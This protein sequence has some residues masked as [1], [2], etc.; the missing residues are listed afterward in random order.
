MVTYY[1]LQGKSFDCDTFDG[2]E[3]TDR[4]EIFQTFKRKIKEKVDINPELERIAKD[5]LP[6]PKYRASVYKY[7]DMFFNNPREFPKVDMIDYSDFE[8]K[9]RPFPPREPE[10]D[11]DTEYERFLGFHETYRN[12]W[13]NITGYDYRIGF[14]F[15][16]NKR[17][18]HLQMLAENRETTAFYFRGKECFRAFAFN[19]MHDTYD[20][21]PRGSWHMRIHTSTEERLTMLTGSYPVVMLLSYLLKETEKKPLYFTNSDKRKLGMHDTAE[22]CFSW[23]IQDALHKK[24]NEELFVLPKKTKFENGTWDTYAERLKYFGYDVKTVTTVVK[25]LDGDGEEQTIYRNEYYIPP[26]ICRKDSDLIIRCINDSELSKEEKQ[27]LVQ[28][29][30]SESGCH[31]YSKDDLEESEIPTPAKE[32]MEWKDND[33]AL[34]IYTVMRLAARPLPITSTTKNLAKRKENLMGLIAEHYGSPTNRQSITDNVKSMV[35][36]G[37]LVK[38][39]GKKYAFDI[40]TAL[41]ADDLERLQNCIAKNNALDENIK[42]RV[43]N[44]IKVKFKNLFI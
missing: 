27:R 29:F 9:I 17:G 25:Y 43:I 8:G 13:Q 19:P 41:T 23:M 42:V 16:V 3:T 14:V 6:S 24:I 5:G 34:I 11:M 18:F 38:K 36:L 22:R 10:E 35:A 4:K 7:L 2:T 40:S 33:Y 31:R 26:F 37:L 39:E 20:P 15:A 28:K 1:S 12:D 30:I 44:K 32:G 21:D